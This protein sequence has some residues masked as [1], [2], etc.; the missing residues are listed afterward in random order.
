M[1]WSDGWKFWTKYIGSQ[2]MSPS[3]ATI[4][5]RLAPQS[6][7]LRN[8]GKALE[9]RKDLGLGEGRRP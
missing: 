1:K 8:S 6:L 9:D 4:K 7:Y 3:T 2:P 5:S